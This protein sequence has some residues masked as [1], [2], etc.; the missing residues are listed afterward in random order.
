MSATYAKAQKLQLLSQLHCRICFETFILSSQH[1]R[2]KTPQRART[3]NKGSETYSMMI[4]WYWINL[5]LW[6]PTR[7][8]L[9]SEVA[10]AELLSLWSRLSLPELNRCFWIFH[11]KSN[12]SLQYTMALVRGS[13]IRTELQEIVLI[14]KCTT[15][16]QN[17]R[18]EMQRKH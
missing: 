17:K 6:T 2:K 5:S 8:H 18:H 4:G 11:G 10:R 13:N 14:K 7:S 3:L 15:K 16:L 9:S 1:F 12:Q